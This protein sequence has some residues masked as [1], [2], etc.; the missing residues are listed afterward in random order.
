MTTFRI[1]AAVGQTVNHRYQGERDYWRDDHDSRRARYRRDHED[2]LYHA[3]RAAK[4]DQFIAGSYE[5][6]AEYRR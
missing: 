4:G 5:T 3:T 6:L 1:N 2:R